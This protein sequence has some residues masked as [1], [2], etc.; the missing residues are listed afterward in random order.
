MHR[1]RVSAITGHLVIASQE[2]P[3]AGSC[4]DGA[5][6]AYT[7]GVEFAMADSSME[8]DD[9]HARCYLHGRLPRIHYTPCAMGMVHM[10]ATG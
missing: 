10:S 8:L 5:P 4:P 9:G 2:V 3:A 6:A 1:C 7:Q